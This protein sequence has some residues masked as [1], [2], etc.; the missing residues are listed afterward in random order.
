[1]WLLFKG[2]NYLRVVSN[3][4]NTVTKIALLILLPVDMQ[5][6]SLAI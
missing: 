5:H 6:L 3:G 2:G 1:M 4:K